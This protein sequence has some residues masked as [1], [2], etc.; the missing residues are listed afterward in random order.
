MEFRGPKTV[1]RSSG[2]NE[3]GR[4]ERGVRRL[5]FYLRLREMMTRKDVDV[6][7]VGIG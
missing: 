4:R 7:L 6:L 2:S 3:K 1:L 5:F